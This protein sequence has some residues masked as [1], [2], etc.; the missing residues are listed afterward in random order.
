MKTDPR[1]PKTPTRSAILRRL[2]T[3]STQAVEQWF[4]CS[5]RVYDERFQKTKSGVRAS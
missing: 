4:R 2:R 3:M 1:T 5:M